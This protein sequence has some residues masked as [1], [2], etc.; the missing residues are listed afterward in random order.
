MTHWLNAATMQ[1]AARE[2][3]KIPEPELPWWDNERHDPYACQSQ[4]GSAGS[5]VED[6]L[7]PPQQQGAAAF[8]AHR[9]S[10]ARE[11]VPLP[12]SLGPAP[13]LPVAQA[14]A[15]QPPAP[16]CQAPPPPPPMVPI[17]EEVAAVAAPWVAP[18]SAVHSMQ[19]NQ[20]A[21]SWSMAEQ[22]PLSVDGRGIGI[23]EDGYFCTYC[24]KGKMTGEETVEKHLQGKEHKKKVEERRLKEGTADGDVPEK[25]KSQGIMYEVTTGVQGSG[26][27]C[28][29]CQGGIMTS[30][31][32]V[33]M[34]CG[35]A[36][37]VKAVR[38]LAGVGES[39]EELRARHGLQLEMIDATVMPTLR[40]TYC[41]MSGIALD[42][43]DAHI[44]SRSHVH[45][46][47]NVLDEKEQRKAIQWNMPDY[48]TEDETRDNLLCGLCNAKGHLSQIM[49]HLCSQTHDKK[50]IAKGY[51][52]LKYSDERFRLEYKN[53]ATPVVRT[54][55][56]LPEGEEDGGETGEVISIHDNLPEYVEQ[57]VDQESGGCYFRCT[58][59]KTGQMGLGH[60]YQHL[61][62]TK[63]LKQ[64][65][66][67]NYQE[68]RFEQAGGH[69]RMVVVATGEP[70]K[71][72]YSKLEGV[73]AE[74][75]APV[76]KP[77]KSAPQIAHPYKFQLP[78]GYTWE[79]VDAAGLPERLPMQPAP[80]GAQ[81]SAAARRQVQQ[82]KQELTE[83]A[84]MKH[85]VLE[86]L[87]HAEK[88]RQKSRAFKQQFADIIAAD[89]KANAEKGGI[90]LSCLGPK[91]APPPGIVLPDWSK[92]GMTIAQSP[93]V[94]G[95]LLLEEG[96]DA[97]QE[98]A[99]Q[100]EVAEAEAETVPRPSS[101][102][103][104]AHSNTARED[105]DAE[106]RGAKLP[107]QQNAARR[108]RTQMG[109]PGKD[110]AMALWR[111][112][113]QKLLETKRGEARPT[114]A[115]KELRQEMLFFSSGQ[116]GASSEQQPSPQAMLDQALQLRAAAALSAA[117]ARQVATTGAQPMVEEREQAASNL[118]PGWFVIW[119]KSANCYAYHDVITTQAQWEK[120][121]YTPGLWKKYV[122]EG[123]PYWYNQSS[124]R[125]F[126]VECPEEQ[127]WTHWTD[128]QDND[129]HWW[130]NLELGE[131][132][133]EDEN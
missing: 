4:Q 130:A 125:Y 93:E 113:V 94:R 37:H 85:K 133:F 42:A 64:C 46:T 27:R 95:S 61:E 3:P 53:T 58:L 55:E 106:L 82:A 70:V 111:E 62:S 25:F 16:W 44:T 78:N 110:L 54:G 101:K 10:P 11:P 9:G 127:G 7:T 38:K 56:Q 40:C 32:A 14:A 12:G 24:N 8:R 88:A 49:I 132:F 79:N 22:E 108:P 74:E 83:D 97:G 112:L 92:L 118:P 45:A 84:L 5:Q 81:P 23:K 47:W 72:G 96:G 39:P 63:H 80:G 119:E 71:R 123:S 41:T 15:L 26:Y 1:E 69:A 90:N 66:Y 126:W 28:T 116:S 76:Q 52:D 124:G 48:V 128:S 109:P 122:Q 33:E 75:A 115:L 31:K 59:C 99:G 57:T 89:D 13:T 17:A 65:R 105:S 121:Q 68:I 60:T 34:H 129:R 51:K 107:A 30:L 43:V 102:A 2:A 20:S 103:G 35:Q 19:L 73:P 67:N 87:Q 98:M 100:G 120:P 117:K 131:R 104:A 114:M 77:K 50:C 36:K 18:S 6:W 91:R 21:P 29:I 86:L